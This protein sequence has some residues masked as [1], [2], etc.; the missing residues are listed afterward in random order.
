MFAVRPCLPGVALLAFLA[1][2]G[3]NRNAGP[4]SGAAADSGMPPSDSGGGTDSGTPGPHGGRYLWDLGSETTGEETYYTASTAGGFFGTPT[5]TGDLNCD[6]VDDLFLGSMRAPSGFAGPCA[7]TPPLCAAGLSC[8]DGTC[9]KVDAGQGHIFFS[10]GVIAGQIDV[11]NPGTNQITELWG[12]NAGDFFAVE[13]KIADHNGDGCADLLVGVQNIDGPTGTTSSSGA[14]YV[15]FGRPTWPALIDFADATTPGVL[16]IY[17]G[18]A[19]D[20]LGSWM[21]DVDVD[22]DGVRDIMIGADAADYLGRMNVGA[23]YVMHGDTSWSAT[24]PD[25][26]IDFAAGLPSGT[27]V[28]YGIDNFDHSGATH[29]GLDIDGDGLEEIVTS[30]G[31]NRLSLSGPSGGDPAVGGGD[32][33]PTETRAEAGEVYIIWNDGALP[34]V[35]DLANPGT[36]TVTTL[37]GADAG[38]TFGED[39]YPGDINAD[40]YGDLV[41]GALTGNGYL[42]GVPDTGEA[43]VLFGSPALRGTLWMDMRTPPAAS[44]TVFYGIGQDDIAGDTSAIGDFNGDGYDDIAIG[45]PQNDAAPPGDPVRFDA[46]RVDVFYGGPSAGVWPWPAVIQLA[47]P[48]ADMN[49]GTLIGAD[50]SDLVSYS[51]DRGD[52]DDD[53]VDDILPNAMR[54]DGFANG[55]GDTGEGYAVSGAVLW[56]HVLDTSF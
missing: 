31:V 10:D 41:I 16:R 45:S 44:V 27:M 26:A 20:R 19:D 34:S 18:A 52:I 39:L 55:W 47:A 33:P 48:P 49:I 35:I 40:G 2:G 15:V 9:A 42:N 25:T 23:T 1:A 38:D 7:A 12:A 32:G 21:E 28:V 54:G 5:E 22:D 53:G 11:A 6:G 8:V 13:A 51:M 50:V 37:Y 17:G 56:Q 29:T 14:L 3:C 36:V 46:G 24:M 43:Y 30:A 4:D